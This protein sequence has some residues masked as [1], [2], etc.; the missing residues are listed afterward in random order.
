MYHNKSVD[1]IISEI[2][3]SLEGLSTNEVVIRQEKYGMNLL[4]K[5]K[6]KSIFGLFLDEFK[7]SIVILLLVVI[8]I[9][10]F[11][12][13]YVDA[14]AITFIILVDAVMGTY[15]SYKANCTAD[16]LSKL[17]ISRSK[18]LRNNKNVVV[19]AEDLVIGDIVCLESGDKVSADM[20]IIEASNLMVDES[21]LTGESMS[22]SKNSN[23]IKK[24]NVIISDQAN[25]LFSGTTVVYGRAKAIVVR[26]GI[27]TELGKIAKTMNSVPEEKSPLT[28]R[29]EKL[30]K[31]ISFIILIV[32]FFIAVLLGIKGVPYDEIFM[33]VIAL[34]VSAMPEGLPL[35]LTMAL[36]IASNKMA[37]KNV[38]VRNLNSAEALGSCTV[39]ASDKTGTLTIDEQTVKKIF[40]PNGEL[41]DISD[42]G[43]VEEKNIKKESVELVKELAFL[44]DINNEATDDNNELVGDSIDIAFKVF[45]KKFDIDS[46]NIE[47]IEQIPYE[48]EKKYSA[49]FYKKDGEIYCT[50]KGS[51]EMVKSFSNKINLVKEKIDGD[52]LDI[53]NEKL[54]KDGY[55]VLAIANGKVKKKDKYSDKDISG[56]TFMG[57]VGFIDPVREEAISSINDCKKAGIKVLMI[58]GDHPLTAF[59]I[60]KE[61]DLVTDYKQVVSGTELEKE[62]NKNDLSFD[63][64]ISDKVIFARVTPLQKLKI[65]ESLKRQGEFVAVTGDGVNDAPALKTANIGIAMGSGTDLARD[66]ADMIISD[67]NFKSIVSGIKEGRGAYENIR[68]ILYFLLSCGLAEVIFF[69][70]AI[71]LD[72]P[73]PLVAIQLLWLNVVTDGIQDFAMSFEKAEDD[74]LQKKP[75]DPKESIFDKSLFREVVISGL[76]IGLIVLFFWKYLI[77][78]MDMDII[79]ARTYVMTLLVFIQNIHVFN[80]RS[81]SKSAFKV[82]VKSN[83]FLI[84]GVSA[85]ILLH[86]LVMENSFLAKI[87]QLKSLALGEF[88][89]IFIVALVVLLVM[90][91]YKIIKNVLKNDR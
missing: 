7:N 64:F 9:S 83:P 78:N 75:R 91:L 70:I 5:K 1:E 41:F 52:L 30:T 73:I 17:I 44:G 81:E 76:T 21:V 55:R 59:A 26:I 54:A 20:R 58:T 82:P 53:Q 51:L 72:L 37:R 63:N 25:I 67:D 39:I 6:N 32:A 36:T 69:C 22:V 65:V 33:S 46:S 3:S 80:C 86:I 90:E 62:L 34:S 16:S 40:L 48:S 24:E 56:L 57:M 14:L 85:T 42:K 66:T 45:G 23:I 61:L 50:V 18:V 28:I 87:L 2:D 10:F 29:M 11:V 49:L 84:F 89:R 79:L 15:Q 31:Q 74:I 27:D 19:N 77:V 4:P 60:G 12:G 88:I 68:K 38:I 71:F 8:V 43:L 47:I 35:A 13:E